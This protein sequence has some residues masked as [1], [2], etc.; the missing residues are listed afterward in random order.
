MHLEE[1]SDNELCNTIK[2]LS[3]FYSMVMNY[4]NEIICPYI[5]QQIQKSYLDVD[6]LPE[7]FERLVNIDVK[8]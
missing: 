2:D 4:D 1:L 5:G 8:F 7:E 6:K 3:T